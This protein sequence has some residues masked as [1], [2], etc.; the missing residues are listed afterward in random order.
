MQTTGSCQPEN[1]LILEMRISIHNQQ[2]HKDRPEQK[3]FPLPGQQFHSPHSLFETKQNLPG[4]GENSLHL[5]I[6]WV[7]SS[8]TWNKKANCTEGLPTAE[9]MDYLTLVGPSPVPWWRTRGNQRSW[10]RHEGASW[11]R[12][13]S[14][15]L[16]CRNL[17]FFIKSAPIKHCIAKGKHSLMANPSSVIYYA[18]TYSF[19]SSQYKW[20]LGL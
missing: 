9:E 13:N 14:L 10:E 18:I 7:S 17:S 16:G 1:Y 11:E 15:L 4:R 20:H 8:W 3:G 6:H 2:R 19:N 5:K 12:C